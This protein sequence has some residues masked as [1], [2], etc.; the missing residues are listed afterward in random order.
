VSASAAREPTLLAAVVAFWLVVVVLVTSVSVA[1]GW[2]PDAA[3]TARP[4]PSPADTTEPAG[5]VAV[6]LPDAAVVVFPR[7]PSRDEQ[8]VDVAGTETPL[9]LY[10]VAD[11]DGTTFS[12]GAI[13]YPDTVDV[14]DPAVNLI[15]SVSGAAANVGG[16]VI[17]QEITVYQGA[18]A[19]EFE[20]EANGVRLLARNV[21]DGRRLYTLSVAFRGEAPAAA[22]AFLESL[23]L[24]P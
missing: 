15:G 9:T 14:D 6:T 20:I 23:D 21:L 13:T 24:A 1:Y 17:A 22:E 11:T 4:A 16:R 5:P 12:A 18:P 8:L 3:G 10:S 19:A 7:P 2:V